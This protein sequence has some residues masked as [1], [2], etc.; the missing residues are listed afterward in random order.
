MKFPQM[1]QKEG[2][3]GKNPAFSQIN[4]PKRSEI[5]IFGGKQGGLCDQFPP[6]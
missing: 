4:F 3:W 1:T 6:K 2:V 5:S